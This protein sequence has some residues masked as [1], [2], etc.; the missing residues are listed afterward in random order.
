MTVQTVLYFDICA[1]PIF[2]I[3]LITVVIRRMT[4]GITNRLFIL[5]L[6]LSTITTVSDLAME[7]ICRNLPIDGV[8]VFFASVAMFF[9]FF[10]QTFS[11]LGYYFFSFAVTGTWYRVR[12]RKTQLMI[13]APY[14]LLFLLL[15]TNPFTGWV[16][17]VTETEG[18]SRGSMIWFV[19]AVTMLYA[20]VATAYFIANRKYM[21][22]ER[23]LSLIS[24]SVLIVGS[25]VFQYFFPQFLVEMIATSFAMIL[26]ILF[27]LRPE[28]RSDASVGSL[29][30]EA[31]RAD[32]K[33]ILEM[34]RKVQIAAVNFINAKQL[35]SYLGEERYF[36]YISGII[37]QLDALFNRERV[38]FDIYFEQPG[39]IYV[40]IED[41]DYDVGDCVKRMY[42]DIARRSERE[43]T[44][45]ERLIPRVC[46]IS[47]PDDLKDFDEIIRLGREFPTQIPE[48]KLYNKA[49]DII[50]SPDYGVMSHI[51][52]ILNRAI[53]EKSFRMYY[54]PIYSFERGR[55]I[56]A[57]ALIRLIDADYGFIS[58]ALF[59]PA[60]QGRYSADRGFRA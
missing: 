54:Q 15:V 51:D 29:S 35:Y 16:F 52:E 55:F 44:S 41:M 2:F 9:Y 10:T 42:S 13:A 57:E 60:A 50:R 14:G 32:L 1:L 59:I 4:Q 43:V 21:T 39:N 33:K 24:L 30:Y 49:S 23:L 48:N 25:V 36:A 18:Y 47:V 5:L 46:C 38:F 12:A 40:I 56:S 58:P 45:G 27:V 7:L 26:I 37:R 53:A 31:Y 11:I 3:I 20:I 8:G 22:L 34:N 6:I 28:E 17:T 19:Y